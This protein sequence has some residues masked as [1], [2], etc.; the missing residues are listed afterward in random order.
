MENT[1]ATMK[2]L[3]SG[4]KDEGENIHSIQ[5][6]LWSGHYVLSIVL[7]SGVS[8]VSKRDKEPLAWWS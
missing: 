8:S 1:T 4:L 3:V 2:D 6:I 5:Q 7:V